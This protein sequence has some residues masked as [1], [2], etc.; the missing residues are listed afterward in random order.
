MK[1]CMEDKRRKRKT[2]LSALLPSAMPQLRRRF[3][4]SCHYRLARPPPLCATVCHAAVRLTGRL[5]PSAVPLSAAPPFAVPLSA[6]P[7]RL[8]AH[9]SPLRLNKWQKTLYLHLITLFDLVRF[10]YLIRELVHQCHLF[11]SISF[12]FFDRWALLFLIPATYHPTLLPSSFPPP[13]SPW[14][15]SPP[16]ASFFVSFFL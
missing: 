7:R 13:S 1:E 11:F 12:F 15:S 14:P 6:P 2:R 4:W 9:L 3:F 8:R 5:P 10:H 16:T